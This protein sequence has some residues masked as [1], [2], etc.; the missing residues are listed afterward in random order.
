MQRTGLAIAAL[1]VS[2]ASFALMCDRYQQALAQPN[3]RK[4]ALLI[5]INQY[6]EQVCD[7]SVTKGSVLNGCLTDVDLQRELLLHRFGFQPADIVTLTDLEATRDAIETTFFEHLGQAQA[8]DTVI[9]HISGLG[10]GVRLTDEGDG[11]KRSIVPVDGLLPSDDSPIVRD[12]MEDTL[13]LMVRSLR[14]PQVT[15]VLDLSYVDLAPPLQGSLRVRSR[16]N[17]PVG[18]LLEAERSLQTRLR[19]QLRLASSVTAPELFSGVLLTASGLDQSALEG[20]WEGFSAGLFTYA[21]TQHLWE[22]TAPLR[23]IISLASTDLHV[24][25]GDRQQPRLVSSNYPDQTI[26]PYFLSSVVEGVDG[27]IASVDETGTVAQ[28]WLGGL[29]A[30]VLEQYG[31]GS[32]LTLAESA[33]S[34]HTNPRAGLDRLLQVRSREGVMVKASLLGTEANSVDALPLQVGQLVQERVRLIPRNVGLTVALDASLER[35]ERVDATSA[36]A[37]S[38]VAVIAAGEQ[39]ADVLFGKAPSDLRALS[40]S[41]TPEAI[42]SDALP[43]GGTRATTKGGYGLFYPSHAVRSGTLS[44]T[45]EAVKTAITRLTPQ[46]RTLLA[47]KLLRLMTNIDTSRVGVRATL[48]LLTPQP[49]VLALRETL[50]AQTSSPKGLTRSPD[51]ALPVVTRGSSIQVQLLNDG[52]VPLYYMMVG[53]N[54]A[55]QAIAFFP[56]AGTDATSN[57]SPQA[58]APGTTATLPPWVVQNQAGLSELHFVVSH[59]PLTQGMTTLQTANPGAQPQTILALN[60]PVKVVQALLQDLHRSSQ[61]PAG[62]EPPSDAYALDVNTYAVFSFTYQVV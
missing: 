5:G 62:L 19:N 17:V 11:I 24:W 16:P 56:S 50:R 42:A 14:T 30:A 25:A 49:Q 8:G 39:A 3:R 36:F 20:Q 34:R 15:T 28:I 58:I 47:V 29:P 52:K 33:Q 21:L 37:S 38:R 48:D 51:A 9:V 13:A 57:A 7:S 4:L 53:L 27:A 60:S 43:E 22:T 32:V 2:E 12:V 26:Q 1:G 54:S 18:Q 46:L 59:N 44:D 55:G 31:A 40:A 61:L 35:I 45:D 23:S 10:S 6:P 41:L